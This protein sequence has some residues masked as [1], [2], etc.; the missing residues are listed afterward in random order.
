M[1]TLKIPEATIIRLSVY[2][3]YLTEVDRKG[4]I[5]ISSGD[6][7][8]GVGVS[9]AQ[10]RKDLAYFGE[11][12]TRGVGYNVKDLHHH[13][14]KILGLAQDWSVTLVG[15]GNLGLALTSYKGF[16][17]RGFIITSVFDNDPQ[18]I[19]TTVNGVE[20]MPIEKLEEVVTANKTQIGIISVPSSVAQE[21]A[22]KLVNSGV[23]AIL[24]F[25]PGVLN[26]PPE[27]EL[28]NVDLAVNLE[29]LTFNVG[30]QRF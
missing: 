28:R 4:I 19:G 27:V 15:L 21:I 13:I 6:V 7:A 11:F 30:A 8:E 23:K 12:G 29:V 26:V 14:L 2:S 17:E 3:R 20:V 22:D 10:V 5:T 18:K 16:R 9:P 24:N 1:K 25:A